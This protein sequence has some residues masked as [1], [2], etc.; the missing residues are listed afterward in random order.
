[1]GQALALTGDIMLRNVIDPGEPFAGENSA[2]VLFGNLEGCLYDSD[3]GRLQSESPPPKEVSQSP[4]LKS[5][6]YDA[7]TAAAPFLAKM[8]FDAVGCANNVTYGA[9]AISAS[10]A[11]L[12][13]MGIEHTGAG[14]D[15]L[16]ARA[17][18]IVE[19][20]G[21]RIGFLQYT[22][23]YH[24]IGHEAADGNAGVATVKA[25]T[26]YK[27]HHDVLQMPGAPAT[28]VTWAD[29]D[30]LGTMADDIERLS[31]DV[32][33]VVASYHWG[34]GLEVRPTEYQVEIAHAAIDAGAGLVMGHG[35]HVVQPVEM[36][37]DK[38]VF[39]GL[40]DFATRNQR[41]G[42]VVWVDIDGRDVAGLACSPVA[43]DPDTG[44]SIIRDATDETETVE[45]L[46]ETSR[47]L[48]T[49]LRVE[50]GRL[51]VAA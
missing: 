21:V 27:P 47:E 44:R 9:D 15:R 48:G 20:D 30:H 37:R 39:Y 3:E 36:Y 2:D 40:G 41:T 19:R 11:I 45:V 14:V 26:A 16:S 1:M 24:P 34:V 18:A 23:T 46:Q 22:S 13:E 49:E 17:P 7:G 38:P 35:P 6:R 29:V 10:L 50:N 51:V 43:H 28:A 12:D 31:R 42:L 32:D 33:F 25:Y 5:R 4:P 8:G